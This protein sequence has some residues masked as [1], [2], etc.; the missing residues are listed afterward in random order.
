MPLCCSVSLFFIS[1]SLSFSLCPSVWFPVPC[2][3]FFRSSVVL[4]VPLFLSLLL[5]PFPCPYYVLLH[6]HPALCPC[7]SLAPTCCCSPRHSHP[8]SVPVS[9]SLSLSCSLNPIVSLPVPHRFS[10]SGCPPALLFPSL[11][12]CPAAHHWIF[13]LPLSVLVLSLFLSILLSFSSVFFF[14]C[15]SVANVSLSISVLPLSRCPSHHFLL[16]PSVQLA[17]PSS[18]LSSSVM[19]PISIFFPLSCSVSLSFLPFLCIAP[20]PYFFSCSIC[21]SCYSSLFFISPSLSFSGFLFLCPSFFLHP[22]SCPF[23]LLFPSVFV[24]AVPCPSFLSLCP[25]VLSLDVLFNYPSLSPVHCYFVPPP[26]KP[27]FLSFS[28]MFLLLPSPCPVPCPF[29]LIL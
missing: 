4:P 17:V 18:S 11:P 16:Y 10:V 1:P 12:L 21:L 7:F 13:F 19:L 26:P 2:L 6:L 28:A 14:L 23:P 24:Y 27:P 8:L 25:S 3:F 15:P 9:C 22:L 5:C 29:C 20:W